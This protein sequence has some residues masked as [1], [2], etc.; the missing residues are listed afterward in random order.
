MHFGES[1]RVPIM[2]SFLL[3]LTLCEQPRYSHNQIE[4]SVYVDNSKPEELFFKKL[5]ESK[6]SFSL[7][8]REIINSLG[9]D[10]VK[11]NCLTLDNRL[12]KIKT[13]FI[14]KFKDRYIIREKFGFQFGYKDIILIPMVD[15][16][17]M[18]AFLEFHIDLLYY[19][20]EMEEFDKI[21]D[22][23]NYRWIIRDYNRRIQFVKDLIS[24]NVRVEGI[25]PLDDE[26]GPQN[27]NVII[28]DKDGN[29]QT[30]DQ[31]GFKEEPKTIFVKR[32]KNKSPL[33]DMKSLL[34]IID[35]FRL[36]GIF[37]TNFYCIT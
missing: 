15:L 2:F 1:G 21:R 37:I 29:V 27:F 8:N 30:L 20:L 9:E 19:E 33:N 23:Y 5:L 35:E 13:N 32:D 16:D 24:K 4:I 36:N 26:F 7:V 18:L 22:E 28:F 31:L 34:L 11:E 17:S 25:V 12:S 6:S 10:N 3:L 14:F